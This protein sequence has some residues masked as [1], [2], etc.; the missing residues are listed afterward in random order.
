MCNG[1]ATYAEAEAVCAAEGARLCTAEEFAA[2]VEHYSCSDW[3]RTEG[4]F[5]VRQAACGSGQ[6]GVVDVAT[7]ASAEELRRVGGAC[8]DNG[9]DCCANFYQGEPASCAAGFSPST[10]PTTWDTCSNLRRSNY[11]C[12]PDVRPECPAATAQ[13]KVHC[14]KVN[15]CAAGSACADRLMPERDAGFEDWN[16]PLPDEWREDHLCSLDDGCESAWAAVFWIFVFLCVAGCGVTG[17]GMWCCIQNAS[18]LPPT[19]CSHCCLPP[20]ERG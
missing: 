5:W 2:S 10:Q 9:R 13:H 20:V 3:G 8:T 18:P 1:T 7:V 11:E 19:A 6:Q 15:S 16:C 4:S 17:A 12:L 14:C